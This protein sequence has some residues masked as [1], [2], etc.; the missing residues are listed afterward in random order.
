MRAVFVQRAL[1]MDPPL[2]GA[3]VLRE[4][5]D[6]PDDVVKG[7]QRLVETIGLDGYTEVEFRRDANGVAR[8]M[9]INPRL[10]A[11][12]E[13]AVRAGVDFPRLLHAWA[14]GAHVDDVQHYRSGVRM[15]WLGGDLHWLATAMLRQHRPDVPTRRRA[16]GAF[17]RDFFRRASYD[18]VDAADPR[19]AWVASRAAIAR[20]VEEAPARWDAYRNDSTTA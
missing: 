7:A 14:T 3:S 13:V 12:V 1:R 8:L 17:A 2:G 20:L 16:F 9:E 11:S 6:P 4:S 18:Y 10:S 19:P 5:I 15:R